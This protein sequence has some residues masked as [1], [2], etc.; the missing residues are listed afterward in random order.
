MRRSEPFT[1]MT[2]F[3]QQIQLIFSKLDFKTK[4]LTAAIVE[5]TFQCKFFLWIDIVIFS[6]NSKVDGKYI[7]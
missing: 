6:L 4:I 5:A 3:V 2:I 7:R 1:N